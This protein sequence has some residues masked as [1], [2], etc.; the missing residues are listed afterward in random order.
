MIMTDEYFGLFCGRHQAEK[1][2]SL[3]ATGTAALQPTDDD[4]AIIESR[5]FLASFSLD[6]AMDSALVKASVAALISS[7]LGSSAGSSALSR[8]ERE[9]SSAGSPALSKPKREAEEEDLDTKNE[10]KEDRCTGE[11][12]LGEVEALRITSETPPEPSRLKAKA[13]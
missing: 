10:H 8:P 6:L 7:G 1:C 3:S 4:D 11:A 12:R 2:P 9:G 5:N 13:F